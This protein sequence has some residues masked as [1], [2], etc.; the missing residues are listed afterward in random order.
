[1]S[2]V[3]GFV[4]SRHRGVRARSPAFPAGEPFPIGANVGCGPA[5]ETRRHQLTAAPFH[6][7]C[8]GRFRRAHSSLAPRLPA[9][10]FFPLLFVCHINSFPVPSPRDPAPEFSAIVGNL[11]LTSEGKLVA[12]ELL[13]SICIEIPRSQSLIGNRAREPRREMDKAQ[14]GNAREQRSSTHLSRKL[15]LHSTGITRLFR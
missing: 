4:R 5:F 8:G 11:L 2:H 3:T 15:C 12:T 6:L 1:M 10:R 9:F 13:F 7:T 14:R